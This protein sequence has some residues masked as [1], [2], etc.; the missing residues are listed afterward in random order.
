MVFASE[1]LFYFRI[2]LRNAQTGRH[3]FTLL[4]KKNWHVYSNMCIHYSLLLK[5]IDIQ[6]LVIFS[7]CA[8]ILSQMWLLCVD[9]SVNS[10]SNIYRICVTFFTVDTLET[11]G[12]PRV[13]CER[14]R[15]RIQLCVLVIQNLYPQKQILIN[16][17]NVFY[18][19]TLVYHLGKTELITLSYYQ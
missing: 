9:K 17:H 2:R 13:L 18:L 8:N 16:T 3:I 7:Y 15:E 5:L 1:G 4:Q 6:S 14:E 12:Q 10:D 19:L 11:K